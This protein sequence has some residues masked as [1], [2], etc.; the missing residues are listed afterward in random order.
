MCALTFEPIGT[1]ASQILDNIELKRAATRQSSFGDYER[2]GQ[3]SI[4]RPPVAR[5]TLG[6]LDHAERECVR[7][8][9]SLPGDKAAGRD[10]T[11][12]AGNSA[13]FRNDLRPRTPKGAKGGRCA[14]TPQL[15]CAPP[16][17]L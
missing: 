13:V 3:L 17:R 1:F 8:P 6:G 5:A 11:T 12:P 9:V 10:R 15:S 7:P 4:N 16:M 14:M 2:G